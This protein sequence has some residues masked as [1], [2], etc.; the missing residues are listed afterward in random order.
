MTNPFD[1]FFNSMGKIGDNLFKEFDE[2]VKNLDNF[3]QEET[4]SN[5]QFTIKVTPETDNLTDLIESLIKIQSEL[6][7]SAKVSNVSFDLKVPV[8]KQEA[9][10]FKNLELRSL[11]VLKLK[12]KINSLFKKQL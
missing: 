6:G 7:Y 8:S 11:A 12:K 2:L 4:K 1:S 9:E 3:D 5:F 10:K